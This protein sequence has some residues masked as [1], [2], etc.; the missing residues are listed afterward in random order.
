LNRDEEFNAR[1]GLMEQIETTLKEKK[2]YA[3]MVI[4]V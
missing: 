2:D 1:E 4:L 3:C